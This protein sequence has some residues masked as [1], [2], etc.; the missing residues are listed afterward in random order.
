MLF[1]AHDSPV[2]GD[3][4]SWVLDAMTGNVYGHIVSGDP[5]SNT[6][7]IIP[8]YRVF[9]DVEK[10]FGH[11]PEFPVSQRAVAAGSSNLDP[12]APHDAEDAM[13]D[14]QR[15]VSKEM[16]FSAALF[17][18]RDPSEAAYNRCSALGIGFTPWWPTLCFDLICIIGKGRRYSLL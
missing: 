4:G 1:Q 6:A 15:Q 7:F 9:K 5:S 16:L 11:K 18:S 8:A 17:E 13:L 3:S 10:R 14:H 2:D 12:P